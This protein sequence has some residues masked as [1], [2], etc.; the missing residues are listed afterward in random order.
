[1]SET[2]TGAVLIAV[3]IL[4]NV[5]FALLAQRFNHP[6]VLR[7]PTHEVLLRFRPGGSSLLLIWWGFALS[8]ASFAR[9]QSC[10][11]ASSATPTRPWSPSWWSSES[12]PRRSSSSA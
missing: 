2:V 10:W 11:P 6:D 4:F 12:L 9:S 1:M 5:G 7:Q 8:A 3:P